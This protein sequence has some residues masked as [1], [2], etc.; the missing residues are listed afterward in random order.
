MQTPVC[1]EPGDFVTF[2]WEDEGV[3]HNAYNTSAFKVDAAKGEREARA[4]RCICTDVLLTEPDR[5]EYHLCGLT[6]LLSATTQLLYWS[7]I[8]IHLFGHSTLHMSVCTTPPCSVSDASNTVDCTTITKPPPEA[9]P[10]GTYIVDATKTGKSAFGVICTVSHNL[11]ADCKWY[12]AWLC[13]DSMWTMQAYAMSHG[14]LHNTQYVHV[15]PVQPAKVCMHIRGG[16]AMLGILSACQCCLG[17]Q[18]GGGGHCT[19]GMKALIVITAKTG[20]CAKR[21]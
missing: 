6:C 21:K 11:K 1:L 14:T 16:A 2:K 19:G 3:S 8:K 10:A 15:Y 18:V 20:D 5:H 7:S 13:S 4:R 12:A 9:T 17:A